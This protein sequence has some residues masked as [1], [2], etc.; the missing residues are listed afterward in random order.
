MVLPEGSTAA[1]DTS[2]YPRSLGT[3]QGDKVPHARHRLGHSH[4]EV[5]NSSVCTYF[6]D[7]DSG[8]IQA[9]GPAGSSHILTRPF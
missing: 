1:P 9:D 2:S 8:Q 3:I 6:S 7:R 4:D 5:R